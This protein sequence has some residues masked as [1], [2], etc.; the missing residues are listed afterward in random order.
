MSCLE[1]ISSRVCAQEAAAAEAE[2]IT[3]CDKGSARLVHSGTRVFI[4]FDRRERLDECSGPNAPECAQRAC[5]CRLWPGT[6][7]DDRAQH[8]IRCPSLSGCRAHTEKRCLKYPDPLNVFMC[9]HFRLDTPLSAASTIV[10]RR[11]SQKH[12]AY[13]RPCGMCASDMFS[14]A[15]DDK[16]WESACAHIKHTQCSPI[17]GPALSDASWELPE[18]AGTR[19]RDFSVSARP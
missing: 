16:S 3:S 19:C 5:C 2:G 12:A 17:Q 10:S 15:R 4:R 1:C 9:V 6:S 13:C 8:S 14:P 18:A 11:P 7:A